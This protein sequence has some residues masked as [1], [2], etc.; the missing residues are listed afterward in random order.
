MK[1]SVS[2]SCV[3]A[4]RV[5]MLCKGV[6][7]AASRGN[8]GTG[9]A[10]VGQRTSS[11]EGE[12]KNSLNESCVETSR[13]AA[14]CEKVCV[15]AS[16]G[17]VGTGSGAAGRGALTEM[18]RSRNAAKESCVAASASVAD[19]RSFV[20]VRVGSIRT[21]EMMALCVTCGQDTELGDAVPLDSC[22]EA[23]I[24][25]GDEELAPACCCW[26]ECSDESRIPVWSE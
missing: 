6:C 25:A 1:N 21:C 23:D 12:A 19:R 10:C 14:V 16:G 22:V 2:G 18:Q 13:E 24:C 4:S 9:R 20:I 11:V 3:E 7:A 5:A 8:E 26:R 17:G 15:A